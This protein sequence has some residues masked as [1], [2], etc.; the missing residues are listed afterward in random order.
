MLSPFF[1]LH[2]L[3]SFFL[4]SLGRQ[5][6]QRRKASA[7]CPSSR[8]R[9]LNSSFLSLYLAHHRPCRLRVFPSSDPFRCLLA[10]L[11]TVFPLLGRLCL[12]EACCRVIFLSCLF[13]LS[14]T[15]P[16]GPLLLLLLSI[17]TLQQ[18]SVDR[19]VSTHSRRDEM[20]CGS[21]VSKEAQEEE[22]KT[23]TRRRRRRRRTG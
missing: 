9:R 2:L 17:L 23:T 20:H 18:P 21:S 19:V 12:I 22:E 5:K 14:I 1:R 8:G 6:G 16:D 10:L 7:R 4:S 3:S 15:P 11:S 13:C